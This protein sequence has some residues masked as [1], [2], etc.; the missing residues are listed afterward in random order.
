[1]TKWQWAL[2]DLT[3]ILLISNAAV[4]AKQSWMYAVLSGQCA[5]MPESRQCHP[6]FGR[7]LYA[8]PLRF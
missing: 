6:H 4:H 2:I 3:L 8:P 5:S 1:M 7:I